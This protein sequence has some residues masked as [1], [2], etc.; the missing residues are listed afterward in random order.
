MANMEQR[1]VAVGQPLPVPECELMGP[2]SR[3]WTSTLARHF[4][5]QQTIPGNPQEW[6]ERPSSCNTLT[7][8]HECRRCTMNKISKSDIKTVP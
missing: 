4:G 3:A 8:Q 2:A 7:H 6:R 1:R 5:R